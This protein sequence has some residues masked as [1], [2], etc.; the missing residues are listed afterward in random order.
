MQQ[1]AFSRSRKTPQQKRI[2][3]KNA[4]FQIRKHIYDGG[5]GQ[6]VFLPG[7]KLSKAVFFSP[8]F[9]KQGLWGLLRPPFSEVF[10]GQKQNFFFPPDF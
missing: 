8:Y 9:G 6:F 4:A 10:P 2:I 3:G 1:M 5:D 7:N